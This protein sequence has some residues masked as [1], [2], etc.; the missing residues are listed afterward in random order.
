[1]QKGVRRVWFVYAVVTV[2]IRR[3]HSLVPRCAVEGLG[4]CRSVFVF[5][6]LQG[7]ELGTS[8]LRP[9]RNQCQ[10]AWQHSSAFRLSVSDPL[11]MSISAVSSC[12]PISNLQQ[13]IR[14][15]PPSAGWRPGQK[16]LDSEQLG[17][18]RRCHGAI[19]RHHCYAM[20]ECTYVCA[21]F[22][23]F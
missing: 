12:A 6:D 5:E 8:M 20:A 4:V 15:L 9:P 3:Q 23:D 13:E 2:A 11:R 18:R 19:V 21:G 7:V 1:M 14:P 17:H 10:F 22:S 16:Q